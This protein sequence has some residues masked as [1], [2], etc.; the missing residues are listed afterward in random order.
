MKREASDSVVIPNEVGEKDGNNDAEIMKK[1]ATLTPEDQNLFKEIVNRLKNPTADDLK[2]PR[3]IEQMKNLG[4]ELQQKADYIV[5]LNALTAKGEKDGKYNF[6]DEQRLG[7]LKQW[8]NEDFS[9]DWEI[10]QGAP[11]TRGGDLI[12]KLPGSSEEK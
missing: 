12:S 5:E 9:D 10:A 11:T 1:I 4:L 6:S 7:L 8:V 2:F 3:R